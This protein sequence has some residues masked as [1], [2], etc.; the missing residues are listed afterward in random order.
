MK[1]LNVNMVFL[2]SE[3]LLI[4]LFVGECCVSFCLF[5]LLFEAVTGGSVNDSSLQS[6]YSLSLSTPLTCVSRVE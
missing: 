4:N 3:F 2:F 1:S 6:K 5:W